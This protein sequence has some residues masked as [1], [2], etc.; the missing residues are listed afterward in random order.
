M[1]KDFDGTLTQ[2]KHTHRACFHLKQNQKQRP[3]STPHYV[4]TT[5]A[6]AAAVT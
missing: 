1:N 4:N 2:F 3:D 6:A 5:S